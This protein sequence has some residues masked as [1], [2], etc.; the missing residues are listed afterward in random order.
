VLMDGMVRVVMTAVPPRWVSFLWS[1]LRHGCVAI[2]YVIRFLTRWT[3]LVSRIEVHEM[4]NLMNVQVMSGGATD[5]R[6][7]REFE[8]SVRIS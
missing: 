8:R 3:C 5:K 4:H 6:G 2:W 7:R 1:W